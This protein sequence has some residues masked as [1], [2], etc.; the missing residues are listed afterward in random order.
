MHGPQFRRKL[1]QW[2]LQEAQFFLFRRLFNLIRYLLYRAA[3]S[4]LLHH[5]SNKVIHFLK[6]EAIKLLV[7][8]TSCQRFQKLLVFNSYFR[9]LVHT[10]RLALYSDFDDIHTTFSFVAVFDE[11]RLSEWQSMLTK[12]SFSCFVRQLSGAHH[13]SYVSKK[14]SAD[15]S[16]WRV[17]ASSA[18]SRDSR[19]VLKFSSP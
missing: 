10:Y 11:A 9:G 15:S 17:G 8:E 1:I 7:K 3:Q 12:L 19:A 18:C 5:E 14:D 6:R 13:A 2:P 4:K 16:R